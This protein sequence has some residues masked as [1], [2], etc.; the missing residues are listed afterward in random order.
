LEEGR[1]MTMRIPVAIDYL[2]TASSIV[3]LFLIQSTVYWLPE[4]SLPRDFLLPHMSLIIIFLN[5]P[6]L[7]LVTLAQLLNVIFNVS[8]LVSQGTCLGLSHEDARRWQRYDGCESKGVIKFIILSIAT[9]VV[10]V[11]AASHVA[12]QKKRAN[13]RRFESIRDE[14]D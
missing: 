7:G 10:V 1:K 12:H 5:P 11:V 9:A 6:Y 3:V 4:W 2:L 13:P 8:A 14:D